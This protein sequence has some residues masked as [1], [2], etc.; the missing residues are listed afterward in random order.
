MIFDQFANMAEHHWPEVIPLLQRARLFEFPADAHGT[1][2][3]TFESDTAELLSETFFLPFPVVAIEDPVSCVLLFDKVTDQQGLN[4]ERYFAEC[5]PLDY[6]HLSRAADA[7][8]GDVE[9]L[10]GLPEGTFQISFGRILEFH[11]YG[12][13]VPDRKPMQLLGCIDRSM[14]CTKR[15]VKREFRD[16]QERTILE[17]VLRNVKTAFE[18]FFYFNTPNRF[19]V[20]RE[21]IQRRPQPP[22]LKVTR[23][24]H[25]PRYVLLTPAEIR[26]RIA[27]PTEVGDRKAPE[28]HMRRRHYRR[29]TSD[30]Y[31]EA[32]G[33]LLCIPATWVGP[34]EGVYRNSRYKVRV[35]L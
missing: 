9:A 5:L 16:V 29:L 4:T 12:S 34:E 3:K 8:P 20:E 30:R 25:R 28:P 13:D 32:R 22:H 23:A 24:S 10:R 19:V 18:E 35:D 7:Q 2:P 6:K 17:P 15:T 31:K 1:L 14:V 11:C 26:E 33:K 27:P 21:D